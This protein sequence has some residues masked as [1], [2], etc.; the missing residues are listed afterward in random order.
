MVI[1]N[2][3]VY[4]IF[5]FLSIYLCACIFD[6]PHSCLCPELISVFVLPRHL[7]HYWQLVGAGQRSC[8]SILQRF[9]HDVFGPL[10]EKICS[11]LLYVLTH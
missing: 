2:V 5:V 3:Y 4:M 6:M 7:L 9:F 11:L 10:L 1:Y 8:P